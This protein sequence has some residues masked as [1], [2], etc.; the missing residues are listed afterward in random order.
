M[1][2]LFWSIA[3]AGPLAAQNAAESIPDWQKAAGG[4][5]AFEVATV[6][7]D[8]GPFKPPSFALS[9]D[10]WFRE[11]NGRFHADFALPTYI[12]FAWKIW[13]TGEEQRVVLANLPEWVKTDR[14]DIEATA[15]LHATKDQY[16][17]MMQGLLAERFGLKLHFE[18]KE[19]PVL[20]MVL[21][22]PGKP[23]P[24]LTPHAQGQAC[25]ETPK[26]ETFPKECY[27]YSA[28]PNK[29]GAWLYGSRATSMDQIGKFVGS[30]AGATGEIGRRVVDQTGLT[31]LWDFTLKAP[32]PA[33]AS[34][35]DAAS[36]GPTMLEA[37]QDQLGVRLKPAR[38]VVS[39][40]VVDHVERP[41]E[42]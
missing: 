12:Q 37:V 41:G 9:S 42:N 23:G 30:S 27:S 38:A 40:L 10:E 25:D 18:Q 17:L 1:A 33:Q 4:A 16:R 36:A 31:G 21:A 14:F 35:Q 26:P 32:P 34:P 11:P 6:R 20:A 8:K 28:E 5:M 13:L 39:V 2:L 24:S 3:I 29:D 22:K 19:M 15:P 7:E